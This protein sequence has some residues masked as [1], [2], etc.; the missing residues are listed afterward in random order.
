MQPAERQLR[1]IPLIANL[2]EVQSFN[3]NNATCDEIRSCDEAC[4][5]LLVCGHQ[6]RD[7]DNDGIPCEE[8]CSRRC[9]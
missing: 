9:E 6:R 7:G 3:C 4:Y 1:D 2:I 8:L 5:K